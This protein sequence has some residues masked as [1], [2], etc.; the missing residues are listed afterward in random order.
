MRRSAES[1]GTFS[2]K[3]EISVAEADVCAGIVAGS[4][5]VAATAK[6]SSSDRVRLITTPLS[7]VRGRAYLGAR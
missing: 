4:A 3:D 1:E 6:K 2:A 7:S 5:K